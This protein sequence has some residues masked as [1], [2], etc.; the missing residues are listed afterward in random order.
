MPLESVDE[1]SERGSQKTLSVFLQLKH[2]IYLNDAITCWSKFRYGCSTSC[3]KWARFLFTSFIQF[4]CKPSQCQAAPRLQQLE[5]DE[6]ASGAKLPC[7]SCRKKIFE[8]AVHDRLAV[9]RPVAIDGR[10]DQFDC[11][12]RGSCPKRNGFPMKFGWISGRICWKSIFGSNCQFMLRF[13]Y[14]YI[15]FWS[16]RYHQGNRRLVPSCHRKGSWSPSPS[17]WDLLVPSALPSG[18]H[19]WFDMISRHSVPAA[20]AL[21]IHGTGEPKVSLQ[22]WKWSR[23]L[24]VEFS[25]FS[26]LAVRNHINQEMNACLIQGLCKSDL[27]VGEICQSMQV[28]ECPKGHFLPPVDGRALVRQGSQN[29]Q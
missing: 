10:T 29:S 27:L 18:P 16:P 28:E 9:C 8:C 3:T 7:L 2:W 19:Q 23:F 6:V 4:N 17:F 12:N 11:T 15:W 22:A 26:T 5:G 14:R 24:R 21:W 20:R 1:L 13:G 25:K